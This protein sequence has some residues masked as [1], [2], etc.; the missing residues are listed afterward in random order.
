MNTNLCRPEVKYNFKNDVTDQKQPFWFQWFNEYNWLAYSEIAK[1]AF[2][3]LCVLFKPRVSHGS[4]QGDFIKRPFNK[5]KKFHE[6]AKLYASSAR[7]QEALE[8]STNFLSIMKREQKSID[9]L[10]NEGLA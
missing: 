5:Y 6:S 7:H 1:G 10:V 3:K 8:K 9:V 2:W 4:Y